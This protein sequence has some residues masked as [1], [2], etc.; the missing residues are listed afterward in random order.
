MGGNDD[1]LI[2]QCTELIP[3]SEE[4]ALTPH[5]P[6]SVPPDDCHTFHEYCDRL[7]ELADEGQWPAL[8]WPE[9]KDNGNPETTSIRNVIHLL[10]WADVVVRFNEFARYR[11][12]VG[13]P[14]SYYAAERLAA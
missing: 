11:E 8:Y 3:N 9:L 13:A 7:C 1:E 10:E 14:G 2:S 6:T 12:A 4:R 5:A